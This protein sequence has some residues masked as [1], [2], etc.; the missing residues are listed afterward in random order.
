MIVSSV[1]FILHDRLACKMVCDGGYLSGRKG[2]VYYARKTPNQPPNYLPTKP[3]DLAVP[4]DLSV[5][6][7][8]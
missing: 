1:K 7:V 4:L 8:D 6:F 2:Q 5:F 3:F